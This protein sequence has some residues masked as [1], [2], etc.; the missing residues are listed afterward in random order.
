MSYTYYFVYGSNLNLKQMKASRPYY[1]Y[2]INFILDDYRLIFRSAADIERHLNSKV[3]GIIFLFSDE[4]ER[5]LGKYERVPNIYRKEYFK[6]KIDNNDEC[7]LYYKMNSEG[8][9][10]PTNRYYKAI[11][12]S[13]LQNNLKISLLKDALRYSLYN[14]KE[15]IF[16]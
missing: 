4:Y 10:R 2:T 3:E 8:V 16:F 5:N 12:D 11:Y 14:K 7:V 15:P 1:R 13:Y 9:G 6:C